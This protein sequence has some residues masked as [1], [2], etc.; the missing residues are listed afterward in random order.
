[1]KIAISSPDGKFD[2]PFSAR[3]ARCERFI[4]VDT[5]TRNWEAVPNPAADARGGAG[6][7]VVQFLANQGVAA[8]ITGR[9]GPT[10]VTALNAANIQ[11]YVADGGTPAELLDKFLAN[12]LKQAT[13]AT[14][15]SLHG[16][17]HHA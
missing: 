8:S 10:A 2:T 5:D 14:G 17:G 1:M 15:Q 12:Q 11:A 16:Q 13:E 7:Q 4:F 6:A 3:F 9:Y